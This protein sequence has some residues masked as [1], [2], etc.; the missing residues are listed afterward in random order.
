MTTEESE[1]PELDLSQCQ[2]YDEEGIRCHYRGKYYQL[3][4][5]YL[6]Q[7]CAEGYGL[8][9]PLNNVSS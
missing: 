5:K 9:L 1:L 4:Q 3:A 7:D 2:D 6:C 8:F